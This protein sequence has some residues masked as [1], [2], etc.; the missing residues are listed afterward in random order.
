MQRGD[1]IARERAL[2]FDP[3]RGSSQQ[4]RHAS[5]ARH[6]IRSTT[7]EVVNTLPAHVVPTSIALVATAV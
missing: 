3:S 1:D 2:S 7:L 4:L 5:S 6:R